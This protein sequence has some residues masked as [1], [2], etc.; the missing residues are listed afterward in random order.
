MLLKPCPH[1]GSAD[2]MPHQLDRIAVRVAPVTA[3]AQPVVGQADRPA[4]L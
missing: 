4:A 1:A 2:Y 3:P